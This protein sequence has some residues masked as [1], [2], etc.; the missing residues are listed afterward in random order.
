MIL[1][2]IDIFN[3]EPTKVSR[4]LRGKIVLLYGEMK[5]GKTS[6]AVKFPRPLLL[7]AERG[8]NALSGV[9]AQNIDKW[10]D[11]KRV[12]KQLK[13]PRAKQ[14]YETVILDTVDIFYDMCESYICSREGVDKIGD[15]PYGAGYR[16]VEKEFD[17]ALR[18]IPMLD[19]GLVMISHSE[20]KQFTDEKGQSYN[21]I[22]PTLPKT[23]RKI[24]LRMADIIGYSRTVETEE[25]NKTYLYM[26]GTPRFEAGSRWKYTPNYIEFNYENL[27]NSIADAIEKEEQSGACVVDEHINTYESKPEMNFDDVMAEIK[28]IINE[29]LEIDKDNNNDK[30][31]RTITR[32]VEKHLG[33]G[34]RLAEAE[35]D[36]VDIVA[37]ILEDLEELLRSQTNE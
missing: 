37:L 12:L 36:Q 9:R 1:L 28:T 8:Y 11:F 13:D 15:V 6:N 32:T 10:S 5:S 7:A 22:V 20:D 19:F 14:M 26:R 3:L 16:F 24:V 31:T 18:S 21:K 33:K 4:D 2:T 27:T 23:P 30:N 17:E 29:L 34:K 35:E 25:G